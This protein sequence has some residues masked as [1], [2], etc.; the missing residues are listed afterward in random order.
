MGKNS[1]ADNIL[2]ALGARVFEEERQAEEE[3]K[4]ISCFKLYIM[5]VNEHSHFC[6]N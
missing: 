1:R 5:S 2:L 3:Q 4:I 6:F